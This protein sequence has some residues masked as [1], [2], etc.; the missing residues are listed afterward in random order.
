MGNKQN[1]QE[2]V[3]DIQKKKELA[4]LRDALNQKATT[5]VIALLKACGVR[6][7][8]LAK[9]GCQQLYYSIGREVSRRVSLSAVGHV[10]SQ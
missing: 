9:E 3:N 2:R 6:N 8:E 1:K 7:P 10:V 4:Q 5:K